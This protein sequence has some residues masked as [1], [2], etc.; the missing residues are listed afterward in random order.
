MQLGLLLSGLGLELHCQAHS[1]N[2]L[3]QDLSSPFDRQFQQ[4]AE[5]EKFF[6]DRHAP[7]LA[8]LK[9]QAELGGT[10]L[11]QPVATRWGSNVEL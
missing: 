2:L 4:A 5:V 6:R 11:I 7:S 1:L 8:Y 3:L 9:Q 10:L